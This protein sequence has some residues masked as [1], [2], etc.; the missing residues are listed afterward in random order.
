VYKN[1]FPQSGNNTIYLDGDGLG[2]IQWGVN[3]VATP[4]ILPQPGA[5]V[6]EDD[7]LDAADIDT[8]ASDVTGGPIYFSLDSGFIDPLEGLANW[9]TAVVNGFV[10]GDVLVSMGGVVGIYAPAGALGLDLQGPDTDDLDAL[11][12]VDDGNMQYNMANDFL[13]F[14]VRRGS[15]IIG[16]MD[17][18]MGLP[19]CEGDIL[20]PTAA[21]G[22]PGILIP[23]EKLGLATL[24]SGTV[25]PYEY[26]DD[27]DA[28]D[29]RTPLLGDTNDDGHV[30]I[31]D[32]TALASNWYN[33]APTWWVSG[34]FNN[35]GKVDIQDL[36]AL[37]SNWYTVGSPP[38]DTVP[39]PAT[40]GLLAIGAVALLRSK[41]S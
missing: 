35:D 12:L 36:T 29:V 27:L 18:I 21:G 3:L 20:V 37:A 33:P 6:K 34:D 17:A 40:L 41:R 10:G 22:P 1:W 19:I 32:L 26:S 2:P 30:D 13:A 23:A 38:P 9:N 5:L 14:S 15:A 7:N 31:Q 39:E 8:Q 25:G 4:G 28:L 24:R 16:M 11:M